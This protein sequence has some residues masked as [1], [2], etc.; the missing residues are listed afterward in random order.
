MLANLFLHYA[1]DTWL[2]RHHP[3]TVFERYAD[4]AVLH[5]K[6]RCGAEYLLGELRNRMEECKLVLH[7]DKTKVVYCKDSN[8]KG[9]HEWI[10]FD[11]LGF[12]F[13]PRKAMAK[14]GAVFTSFAPAISKKA[15]KR[16]GTRIKK[17]KIQTWSGH[18]A[19]EIALALNPVIK[20]WFNYYKHFGKSELYQ[21][22]RK[23]DFALVRWARK[24]YKKLGRSYRK[25]TKFLKRLQQQNQRLFA[26]WYILAQ[27]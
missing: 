25:S 23:L 26:H 5:C 13:R 20:G 15:L 21:L 24:K 8:R 17:W 27:G 7:P 11:F 19:H 4:D 16:I 1:L 12:T 6:T 9:K 18:N 10:S 3:E 22:V 14:Q 2:T